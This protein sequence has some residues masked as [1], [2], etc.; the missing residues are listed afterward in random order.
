M[1]NGN[2]G[3]YMGH[4]EANDQYMKQAI[5]SNLG[6]DIANA[7]YRENYYQPNGSRQGFQSNQGQSNQGQGSQSNQYGGNTLRYA[8]EAAQSVHTANGSF[9]GVVGTPPQ[10]SYGG[11]GFGQQGGQNYVQQSQGF[12]GGTMQ[13]PMGNGS[14][15]RSQYGDHSQQ[16][17]NSIQ[18]RLPRVYGKAIVGTHKNGRG[19][20][21]AFQLEDG[22]VLDY[23]Q[24][25]QANDQGAFEGLRVQQNREG[26][27]IIRS[28]PDGF[29]DNNLDNLPQF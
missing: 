27:L 17:N 18:A 14:G 24:M 5:A 10:Q 15:R 2:N 22:T 6:P 29:S 11:Q 9:A 25:L 13:P 3:Q 1:Q 20:I 26:E 7:L 12:S 19:N 16:Y 4:E 28:V 21:E 23:L 8:N